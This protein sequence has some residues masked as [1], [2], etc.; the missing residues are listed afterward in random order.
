MK[1][2]DSHT[3]LVRAAGSGENSRSDWDGALPL[4]ILVVFE[5]DCV[6]KL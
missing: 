5:I 1:V 6:D 4:S 3:R 2:G